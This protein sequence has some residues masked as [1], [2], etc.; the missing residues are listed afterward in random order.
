M[1]LGHASYTHQLQNLW[2]QF[3]NYQK[4]CNVLPFSIVQDGYIIY[5]DIEV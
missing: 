2:L 4:V 1:H 5:N 3:N